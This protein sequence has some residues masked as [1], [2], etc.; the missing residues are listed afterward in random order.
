MKRLYEQSE[1]FEAEITVL[2]E[3][4][5]G[6]KTPPFNGIH[7][8]FLYD[9][10]RP[11]DD[12]FVIWPEFIDT[13]G[14]AIPRDLP[15]VG[16]LRAR[17]YIVNRELAASVHSGRIQVGVNF[18]AMEGPHKVAK[19]VVTRVTGLAGIAYAS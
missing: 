6:R 3:R 4:D 15:L 14:D 7:W 11:E 9:G 13:N 12:L 16:T 1:D 10:D 17:M 2:S 8:D 19:G 5:G 18:F